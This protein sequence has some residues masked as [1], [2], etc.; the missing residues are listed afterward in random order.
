MCEQSKRINKRTSHKPL[1]HSHSYIVRNTDK[2][3]NRQP[4]QKHYQRLFLLRSCQLQKE[5]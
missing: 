4:W 1:T 2:E 3:N 5:M